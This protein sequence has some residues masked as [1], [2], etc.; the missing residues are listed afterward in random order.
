MAT[1][2]SEYVVQRLDGV[3]RANLAVVS[4]TIDRLRIASQTAISDETG[5]ANGAAANLL[6][7]LRRIGLVEDTEI[8]ATG[9]RGRP[10]RAVR[11][12]SR[13]ALAVGVE[14]SVEAV[15][16]SVRGTDGVEL[17]NSYA[18]QERRPDSLPAAVLD[19]LAEYAKLLG[20][21]GL[22]PLAAS[23][24]IALPG[25][26]ASPHLRVPP[27][28]WT[29]VLIPD[30]V[31]TAPPPVRR[32][33]FL[34][35]GDA[36]VIAEAALR[37]EVECVA[38]IHGSDGIGGGVS[39]NGRLFS[40][41]GGAAGQFGHVVVETSGRPCHCGNQGC[42][43]QYISTTAF[44]EDLREGATLSALGHRRYATDLA[45][46]AR[47]GDSAALNLLERA[48]ARLGQAVDVLGAVLS[49]ETV[50]LTG[51]L[52]VLAPWLASPPSS[53]TPAQEYRAEWSRPV[54][55]SALG[56]DSVVSGA[57]VAARAAILDDPLS[58]TTT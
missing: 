57:A 44:A 5:L 52:A 7:E 11:L 54:E 42:L 4:R 51:N 18:R 8:A 36:A 49:P 28:G 39:L 14:V 40:G 50:V 26:V 16:I 32:L 41:A 58:F 17:A 20:T 2:G 12:A 48:K 30:L 38:A 35:D 27:F 45:T 47:R 22:P 21:T 6:A 24:V 31:R 29:D 15:A 13:F 1:A 53:R 37:P 55:G 56:Q 23:L 46:R 10:R 33:S 34:N 43:C 9:A 19:V 25:V 3:R